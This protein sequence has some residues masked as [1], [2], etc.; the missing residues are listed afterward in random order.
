MDYILS[1]YSNRIYKEI[2]ITEDI[3]NISIGTYK[4]C[5]VLLKRSKYYS[6]FRVNISRQ[7]DVLVAS[8]DENS[9]F[10]TEDNGNIREVVTRLI[11]GK[12]IRVCFSELEIPFLTLRFSFDFDNLQDNYSLCI[13]TPIGKNYVIGGIPSGKERNDD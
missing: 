12:N 10:D 2:K 5:Q 6:D 9:Y 7:D 8:C 4:D 1:I 11:P 13:D 3:S